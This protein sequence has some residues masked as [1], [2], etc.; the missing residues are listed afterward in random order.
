MD[1]PALPA[2]PKQAATA[3]T[4]VPMP[5]TCTFSIKRA[6]ESRLIKPVQLADHRGLESN[7][8]APC[9]P[10]SY[11]GDEGVASQCGDRRPNAANIARAAA[12]GDRAEDSRP[13][14]QAG[15]EVPSPA[16]G[17]PPP[18]QVAPLTATTASANTPSS[19]PLT[20]TLCL[21][22]EIPKYSGYADTNS[23]ANFL[24]EFRE[25]KT[26]FEMS[27]VELLPRV[28]PIAL[29]RSVATWHR[30]QPPFSTLQ[31]FSEQF[32]IELL[33]PDNGARILDELKERTQNRDESLVEFVR[34]LQTENVSRAIRQSHPQ[35][36]TYLRGRVFKSLDELAQ[37][38]HQ[39]PADIP[40]ELKYRPPPPPEACLEPSCAWTGTTSSPGQ[41]HEQPRLKPSVMSPMLHH[42]VWRQLERPMMLPL[43]D[44]AATLLEPIAE[45]PQVQGDAPA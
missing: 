29:T 15:L 32:K 37:A 25:Q 19:T 7:K 1:E 20:G 45:M 33:P 22:A 28:L 23:I 39:I 2:F 9:S 8:G 24:N 38:A 14:F 35:F 31:H 13:C 44:Y 10:P 43:T 30:R 17:S 34:A 26:V 42:L 27:E 3:E 18:V 16:E 36:H 21:H 6:P 41:P 4:G 12:T 11:E 40:A 5:P